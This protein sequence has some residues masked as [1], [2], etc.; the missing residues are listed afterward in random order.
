MNNLI[1]VKMKHI[2]KIFIIVLYSFK[3]QAQGGETIWVPQ[4]IYNLNVDI[5]VYEEAEELKILSD[6]IIVSFNRNENCKTENYKIKQ[7]KLKSFS[8]WAEK[9]SANI[10]R[11]WKKNYPCKNIGKTENINFPITINF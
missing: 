6:K 1:F 5:N 4:P 7:G 3:S 10:V 8:K 11:Q 2:F 9:D